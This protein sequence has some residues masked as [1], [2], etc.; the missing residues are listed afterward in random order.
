ML[1][2]RL[3]Q[4]RARAQSARTHLAAVRTEPCAWPLQAD[5]LP[6]LP[7]RPELL[8]GK[9]CE[10]ENPQSPARRAT[11][12]ELTA[13]TILLRRLGR[14]DAHLHLQDIS[15]GGFQIVLTEAMHP[16]D[17]VVTRLPGLEPI[18][19]SVMWTDDGNAGLRFDRAL[20]PAVFELLLK[21]LG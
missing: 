2:Q 19:A 11:A 8:C 18:G 14:P 13:A 9:S 3:D 10:T 21:R 4:V 6:P 1:R 16:N 20:H 5:P 12:R 17:H 15:T 7:S